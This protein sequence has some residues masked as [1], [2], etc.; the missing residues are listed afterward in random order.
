MS[1]VTVVVPQIFWVDE[2]QHK[3]AFGVLRKSRFRIDL[4]YLHKEEKKPVDSKVRV[5]KISRRLRERTQM[6]YQI[7]YLVM[8]YA[9]EIILHKH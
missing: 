8:N 2:R 4:N 5:L 1:F 6:K 9:T 3:T 7:R